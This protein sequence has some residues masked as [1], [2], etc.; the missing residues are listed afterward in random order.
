MVHFVYILIGG[1]TKSYHSHMNIQ[2][3]NK[4][5]WRVRGGLKEERRREKG[6]RGREGRG[7]QKR[8]REKERSRRQRERVGKVAEGEEGAI[9]T[10]TVS[11]SASNVSLLW[12]HCLCV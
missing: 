7:G 8:K 3:F 9:E 11:N 5:C 2:K 10:N 4:V 1:Y 6:E 12:T